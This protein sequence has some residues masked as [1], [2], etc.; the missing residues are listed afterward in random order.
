MQPMPLSA[1]AFA[2][3]L[4]TAYESALE[5]ADAAYSTDELSSINMVYRVARRLQG[6]QVEGEPLSKAQAYFA[7]QSR[8]RHLC[9]RGLTL[10]RIKDQFDELFPL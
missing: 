3:E 8:L 4:N 9:D 2:E 1:K 7:A 10:D 5:D 6:Q